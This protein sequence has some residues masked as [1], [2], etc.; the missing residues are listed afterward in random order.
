MT[1]QPEKM[2]SE[3]HCNLLLA[4]V[5]AQRDLGF[6]RCAELA[7]ANGDLQ[8][9]NTILGA[10]VQELEAQLADAVKKQTRPKAA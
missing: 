4:E 6:K 3:R 9:A 10:R 7:V 2:I 8:A 1:D 5:Q